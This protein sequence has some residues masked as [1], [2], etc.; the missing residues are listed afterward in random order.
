MDLRVVNFVELRGF[1]DLLKR[2]G[3]S[4]AEAKITHV[5]SFP[6]DVDEKHV[7]EGR[8]KVFTSAFR[9]YVYQ[10]AE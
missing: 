5:T 6:H 9:F 4:E 1:G 2:V 7:A 3:T 10:R 8:P